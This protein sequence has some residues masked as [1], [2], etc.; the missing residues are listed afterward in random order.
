MNPLHSLKKMTYILGISAFYHDAAACLIKG[1]TV[2]SASQEERF[3]RRK[4]D[5]DFPVN[6]INH[7][8]ES[9]GIEIDDID[10]IAYYE[11]PS[12]K[13]ER[14][15]WSIGQ[16]IGDIHP[17]VDTWYEKMNVEKVIRKHTG[18]KGPIKMFDHHLSHAASSFYTSS[19]EEAAILVVD[20][21][22]EWATTTFAFGKGKTISTLKEIEFPYSLGLYYSAITSFLGFR[23]NSDEYKVMGM[24]A[25]GE[26]IY[27]QQ[28]N[29][30]IQINSDG[31][32]KMD[33]AYFNYNENMFSEKMQDLF[34]VKPR[35]YKDALEKIHFDIASS[36]QQLIEEAL[37]QATNWLYEQ[38]GAKKLC[39]AGGVALNCLANA[40]LRDRSPFEEIFVQPASGDAGGCFGAAICAYNEL[41][42]NTPLVPFTHMRFGPSFNNSQIE[43]FL[44]RMTIKSKKMNPKDLVAY[45]ANRLN[46]GDIIGWFQGKMEFGPRAL[47]GRSILADPRSLKMKEKINYKIKNREGFRPFAPMCIEE[48][49]QKFFDVDRHYP[50]MTFIVNTL[51]P[52][53]LEAVSHDD[54]TARLQTVS[55]ETDPLM[56]Q[57]LSAFGDITGV[58]V[59]LNTSFNVAGEPIVCT[60]QDAFNCFRES[61]MDMLVMGPYVIERKHQNQEL[62]TAGTRPY[63]SLAREV[64]PY[65]KGTYFFS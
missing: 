53:K 5:P 15:L 26:P 38:T 1:N 62:V 25:Y 33:M 52:K 63:Q 21:V 28:L 39:L 45:C 32:Y 18:Y 64:E 41:E 29:E 35:K 47:G 6:A 20:G 55:K 7:C 36:A 24:A 16:G 8:L 40:T 11:N 46:E 27:R 22:G 34:K 44:K 48:E 17:V 43:I 2:V 50:F 19:F 23:P 60:P 59:L 13:L 56:H 12:K 61:G 9:N 10:C 14:I 42:K 31:T 57:L 58:P 65:L 49:A 4:F 51:Y 37:L 3:T 30:I 54:G